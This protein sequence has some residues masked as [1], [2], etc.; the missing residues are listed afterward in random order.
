MKVLP[1]YWMA[2]TAEPLSVYSC[3]PQAYQEAISGDDPTPNCQGGPVGVASCQENR[4]GIACGECDGYVDSLGDCKVCEDG[5][6][7]LVIIF[8]LLLFTITPLSYYFVNSRLTAW[9]C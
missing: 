1:G 2:D 7:W 6:G 4:F 8:A 5:D 3:G 9:Q